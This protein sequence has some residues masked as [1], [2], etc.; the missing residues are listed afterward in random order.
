MVLEG[1]LEGE[2][3]EEIKA[4]LKSLEQYMPNEDKSVYALGS[5]LADRLK[6]P[7]IAPPGIVNAAN[8]M[9]YDLMHGVS[10]FPSTPIPAKLTGYPNAV[11]IALSMRIPHIIE[12]VCPAEFT[13]KVNEFYK[14]VAA[15]VA[16]ETK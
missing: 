9:M 13:E 14:K 11:Y 5:Y 7:A 8:L 1:V 15:K 16:E 12:A 3:V 2:A 6:T 10:G 4:K